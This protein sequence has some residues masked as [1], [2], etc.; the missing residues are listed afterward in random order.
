MSVSKCLRKTR[1]LSLLGGVK[2]CTRQNVISLT[3]SL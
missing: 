2:I 3:S 1:V